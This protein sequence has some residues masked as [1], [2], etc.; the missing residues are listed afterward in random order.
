MNTKRANRP[1][2]QAVV[3]PSCD[4]CGQTQ[5][6]LGALEYGPPIRWPGKQ[7]WYC[8]KW[9]VCKACYRKRHNSGGES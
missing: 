1:S 7:G 2:V 8:R 6:V 5:V 3:V 4:L 9:H